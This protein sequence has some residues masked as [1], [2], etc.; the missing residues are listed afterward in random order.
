[1][2]KLIKVVMLPTE[3][4]RIILKS[5]FNNLY[6]NKN[7]QI[8][9]DV[10]QNL[11]FLS[12]EKFK[13]GDW[14]LYTNPIS[15]RTFV[16]K[17]SHIT[18]THFDYE[19]KYLDI[20][21]IPIEWAR[22]I[23][24]TTDE[25]LFTEVWKQTNKKSKS[26]NIQQSIET[27]KLVK[28]SLPRPSNEFLKKFC[29][30]GGID[31]VLVEYIVRSNSA[32][33]YKEYVYLQHI[34]GKRFIPIKIDANPHQDSYELGVENEFDDYELELFLK[35]AVDNTITTYPVK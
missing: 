14:I 4:A 28:K 33:G 27:T 20:R 25:S 8:E 6:Y 23:I 24:A 22:K 2:K 35:V 19:R 26:Y 30:V 18:S 31:E 3:K 17:C 29:E 13:V 16:L 9:S 5:A 1:M 21:E 34:E 7:K 11:Y 15:K 10:Y 12:N 32:L